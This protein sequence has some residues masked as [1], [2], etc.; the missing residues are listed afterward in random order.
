MS[1]AD[2]RLALDE[3]QKGLQRQRAGEASLAR[4]HFQRAVKLD[5][6]NADAWHALGRLHLTLGAVPLAMRALRTSVETDP[7]SADAHNDLGLALLEEGKSA[8]AIRS[9]QRALSTRKNFADAAVNLGRACETLGDLV[10][11]ENAYRHALIFRSSHVDA[12]LKLG[13]LLR[14][15]GRNNEALAVLANARRLAPE[16][17]DVA[18]SLSRTLSD[19]GRFSEAMDVARHAVAL[20]P[21]SSI[22]WTTLG[23]A[24]R[25]TRD[26]EGAIATFRHALTID[27]NN[28]NAALELALV[29]DETGDTEAARTIWRNSKPA[30]ILKERVRWLSALS[31]PA[32]YRDD[33]EIETSRTRFATG[34]VELQN[35]LKLDNATSMA[36]AVDASSGVAPFHLHY[37]PNDNTALQC[38]FGDLVSRVMTRAAPALAEPCGWNFRA[39]ERVRVGFVSAHLMEHTVARYFRSMIEELDPRRFDVTVWYTG[40]IKDQSTARIAERVATFVDT[41]ADVLTLAQEI[42]TAQLDVLVYPEIGMDPKHQALAAL[43]LAPVQCALYGHPATSGSANVDYFISSD[44]I[45]PATAQSHYRERLIRLPG[46]GTRPSRPP[47]AGD[48][49]WYDQL[50]ARR[51]LLLCTQNLIKLI[52]SFDVTLAKI[53]AETGACIGLFNRNPPL[54]RR[55]QQRIEAIFATRGLEPSKHLAFIPSLK[56]IDYLAGLEKSPIVLDSPWFSGGATSLDAIS[57][58]APVL[59]WEGDMLR[60]RQ[61]AGMLRMMG[62]DGLIVRSE[63]DYVRECVA[64]LGDK[65]R[66]AAMRALLMEKQSIIFDDKRPITAFAEF[67]EGVKPLAS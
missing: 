37:Q 25:Q 9:F 58:G 27:N 12:M 13:E 40:G 19:A 59:A 63:S 24:Q 44:E 17:A 53:A 22:F 52:P 2:K 20:Q 32:I 30:P 15:T 11:A 38:A 47:L 31:L 54:T 45:E 5:P 14:R 57:V 62:A 61:T 21:Q 3:L 8:D 29:L 18:N 43:R 26:H 1:A 67:L 39:H 56:H 23:V 51:P 55:F 28:V 46:L 33:E 49:A 7:G 42:R 65:D 16:N 34:L 4:S 6:G 48:G 36:A 64:L 10:N 41:R 50:A 60:G 35:G 66:R